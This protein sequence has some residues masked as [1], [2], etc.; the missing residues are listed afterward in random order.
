M[1]HVII[2]VVG[3]PGAPFAE[4][5]A[6]AILVAGLIGRDVSLYLPYHRLIVRPDDTCATI[7]Q[8]LD[9]QIE[10]MREGRIPKNLPIPSHTLEG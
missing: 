5:A 9:A 7:Q 10:A 6:T 1:E 2:H 4:V 8:R 3:M